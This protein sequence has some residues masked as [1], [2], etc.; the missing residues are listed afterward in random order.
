MWNLMRL[1]KVDIQQPQPLSKKEQDQVNHFLD[2]RRQ[3]HDGPTYAII[4][5]TSQIERYA[6]FDA[7]QVDP[8]EGL[9]T[10]SNKYKKKKRTLPQLNTRSYGMLALKIYDERALISFGRARILPQGVVGDP[11]NQTRPSRQRHEQ[12]KEKTRRRDH[13]R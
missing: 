3:I 9:P 10:Y 5:N 8:F 2:L 13:Q 12:I 4:G 1:Q 11:E 6:T 7:A